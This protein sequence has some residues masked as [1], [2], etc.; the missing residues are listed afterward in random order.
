MGFGG[1]FGPGVLR[2]WKLVFGGAANAEGTVSTCTNDHLL[3]YV[4]ISFF[5]LGVY[6]KGRYRVFVLVKRE[7]ERIRRLER[8]LIFYFV[9]PVKLFA[10]VLLIVCSSVVDGALKQYYW[11]TVIMGTFTAI[12]SVSLLLGSLVACWEWWKWDNKTTSRSE[13]M[14]PDTELGPPHHITI[15]D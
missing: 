7:V 9:P 1:T 14:T 5:V 6:M 3:R 11:D 15:T 10:L 8:P 2:L 12:V 4:A 13:M